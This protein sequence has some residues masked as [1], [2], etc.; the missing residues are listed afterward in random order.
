M[1]TKI[2]DLMYDLREDMRSIIDKLL[3]IERAINNLY[4]HMDDSEIKYDINYD[5]GEREESKR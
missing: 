2:R 1:S 4:S 3:L 5:C